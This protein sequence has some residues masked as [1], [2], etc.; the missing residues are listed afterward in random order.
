[1]WN[2]GD[3]WTFDFSNHGDSA[4]L[5]QD[6]LPDTVMKFDAAQDILQLIDKAK[7]KKPIIGIGHSIG[8]HSMLLAEIIR[9]GT[10][11]SILAIEPIINPSY[12]KEIDPLQELKI[13]RRRDIWPNR[14]AAYTSFIMKEFFQNWDPEVLNLHIQY[15]LRELP[16]GEVT[17]KCPKIQEL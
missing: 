4:V 11:T 2:G 14:E 1:Q 13:K 7:I 8:G 3:M 17:L 5:N 16:S 12:I 15:G 6:V 10:F 9:P